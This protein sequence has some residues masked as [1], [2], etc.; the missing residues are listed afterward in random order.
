M[1]NFNISID[2]VGGHGCQRTIKDGG[3]VTGCSQ[4]YCPDCTT[5]EFV[6]FLKAKGV[7]VNAARFTHWP[8]EPSEVVDD[9]ITGIRAGSFPE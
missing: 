9:L 3:I 2:A 5:R 6:A 4:T 1:G 7:T 8:G